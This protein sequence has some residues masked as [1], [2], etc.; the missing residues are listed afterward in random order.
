MFQY[1]EAFLF[2]FIPLFSW[3]LI[4]YNLL[5]R[6]KIRLDIAIKEM[7]E[8]FQ[9][10]QK[11]IPILMNAI[12]QYLPFSEVAKQRITELNVNFEECT[13]IYHFLTNINLLENQLL[14]YI[15]QIDNNTDANDDQIFN[16]LKHRLSQVDIRVKK[17][18]MQ[19]HRTA[20][21]LNIRLGTFPANM[22]AKFFRIKPAEQLENKH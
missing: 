21:H 1:F 19:Y 15:K 8:E 17:F 16:D 13:N 11:L 6:D 20:K 3:F 18:M 10:K 2:I 12:N 4:S 7:A 22:F 5:I 9:E 14:E